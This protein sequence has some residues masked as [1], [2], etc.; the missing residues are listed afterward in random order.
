MEDI[1]FTLVYTRLGYG[2]LFGTI[3]FPFAP[4]GVM[5]IC[6]TIKIKYKSVTDE[7]GDLPTECV[8]LGAIYIP[9]LNDIYWFDLND[10]TVEVASKMV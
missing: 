9:S 3:E 6:R 7:Y 4:E 2:F 10:G 1:L 8:N 5:A